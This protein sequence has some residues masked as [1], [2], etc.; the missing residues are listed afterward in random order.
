MSTWY[1]DYNTRLL[2]ATLSADSFADNIITDP[3]FETQTDTPIMAPWYVEGEG[4][5]DRN[6]GQA[7]T[8]ENNGY[9]RNGSGWNAIKQ[10]VVV[11]PHT[12]YT[13]K[14]WV[15]TSSNNN[16]GYFGARVPNNGPVLSET[17]Y[18]SLSNYTE[19]TVTFNSGPNAYVEL[20]NG[21]WAT[22]DMWSQL[23]D[24]S[25]TRESNL[26]GHPGFEP[27]LSS[28]LTSPWYVNGNAGVDRNLGFAHTGL[29]NAYARYDSGWNAIKQEVFVET[30]TNYTLT[31]WA[32]TSS[33]NS[34][35]YF[36]ARLL[37]GGPVLSET[38]FSSLTNYTKLDVQFNSGNNHSVEVFAGMWA[39]NGDTWIQADTF[40]LTK[41]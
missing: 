23:D 32:R 9:V 28:A 38:Q 19:L 35:G 17:S 11:Q 14:G 12:N 33:N 22:D 16:D 26:V 36:G 10:K 31:G 29:N 5:I 15:R 18:T 20:F 34:E 1:P 3:G 30:N 25:L 27:Q 7:R 13:L 39:S 41:N 2:K 24:V 21:I 6:L 37:N 8:G 4:G 40:S